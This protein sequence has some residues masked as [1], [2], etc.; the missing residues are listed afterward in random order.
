MNHSSLQCLCWLYSIFWRK[1]NTLR[2]LPL[3]DLINLYYK[4]LTIFYFFLTFFQC[5][6][7]HSAHSCGMRK[8]SCGCEKWG[9]FMEW[10]S[11]KRVQDC[12]AA[13]EA[14]S[15]FHRGIVH[16][17]TFN[18]QCLLEWQILVFCFCLSVFPSCPSFVLSSPPSCPS[19]FLPSLVYN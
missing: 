11:G 10:R 19:P 16:A 18:F 7:W 2:F 8:F 1:K 17:E 14:S 3:K 15:Q 4:L 12:Q 6:L 5:G 13:L 9:R